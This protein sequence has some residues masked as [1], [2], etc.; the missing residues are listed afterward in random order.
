MQNIQKMRTKLK[1]DAVQKFFFYYYAD[2]IENVIYL[3]LY[4]VFSE[5][6]FR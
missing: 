2:C 1:K 3:V 4:A 6:C 5:L